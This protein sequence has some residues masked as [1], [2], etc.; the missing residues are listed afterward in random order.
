MRELKYELNDSILEDFKLPYSIKNNSVATS[1]V[2][3]CLNNCSFCKKNFINFNLKSIPFYRIENMASEIDRIY[4]E[5]YPV[6]D[7]AIQSSNLSLYGVDLYGKQRSHEAIKSLTK[8]ESIKFAQLGAI[9]NWYPE[10]LNEIINNPKIKTVFT[11]LESGSER[12]YNL[13]NRPISLNKLIDTIKII[14]I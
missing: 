11:S 12:V 8:P 2:S 3:G 4:C 14:K 5:G 10:L 6:Y 7:I 9:I 13:M 1:I